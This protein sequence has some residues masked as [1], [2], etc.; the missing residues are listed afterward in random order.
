M[1]QQ[2]NDAQ[3]IDQDVA[4]GD[5]GNPAGFDEQGESLDERGSGTG[6]TPANPLSPDA[7]ISS[8][9][10]APASPGTGAAELDVAA[11]RRAEGGDPGSGGG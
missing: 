1:S 11:R 10:D 7:G 4:A 8:A 2:R 5:T 6:P 3:D 9:P